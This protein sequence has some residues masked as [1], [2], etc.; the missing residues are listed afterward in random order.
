M[1]GF[2]A[3]PCFWP[4]FQTIFF[5]H[6][7]PSYRTHTPHAAPTQPPRPP[8]PSAGGGWGVPHLWSG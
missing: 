2:G 3:P 7:L 4:W 8:S 6:V 1:A 5:G